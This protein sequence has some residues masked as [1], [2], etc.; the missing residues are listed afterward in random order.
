MRQEMP[1]ADEMKTSTRK[2]EGALGAYASPIGCDASMAPHPAI[3]LC[4]CTPWR[5]VLIAI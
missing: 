3:C 5:R 4:Q 2:E 1:D